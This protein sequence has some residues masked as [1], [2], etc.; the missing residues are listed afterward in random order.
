M[1]NDKGQTL[2]T[3]KVGHYVPGFKKCPNCE[4]RGTVLMVYDNYRQSYDGAKAYCFV[5]SKKF[6]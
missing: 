5:C 4:G 3:R 2:K 1:S 6:Y